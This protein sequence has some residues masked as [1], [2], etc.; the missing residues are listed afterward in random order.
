MNNTD[1]RLSIRVQSPLRVLLPPLLAVLAMVA[2]FFLNT[3]PA[4]EDIPRDD[5]LC[6]IDRDAITS[7]A[8]FLFDFA[9]P[10]DTAH[11]RLP[12]NLLHDMTL[13]LGRNTELQVFTL[14]DSAGAPRALLTR[15]CKPYDNADLQV[16]TARG[17]RSVDPDCGK[18]PA[19]LADNLRQSATAFCGALDALQ[20]ELNALAD[21]AW[22]DDRSV[23]NAY[24]VEALEDIGLELAERPGPHRLYVFS[25]MMQHASWYSHLD[26]KW[27][28]WNYDEFAKLLASRNW[29]FRQRDASAGMDVEIFYVPRSGT[30][31][32]PLAK[33]FH[34][35]FWRDY[36][37]D[38]EIAFHDQAAMR[39]YEAEPLMNVL[40]EAEMAARERAAIEQLLLE[41]EQEEQAM[42]RDQRELEAQ[43]ARQ[44]EARRQRQ[45][46]LQ[47]E[48]ERQR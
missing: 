31:S 27:M 34:Q 11:G 21:R 5:D 17:Q 6:P 7:S 10:L 33:E 23:A 29:L 12:G 15:L 3:D 24:L 30:T 22:P 48:L 16:N 38:S 25:D 9:K 40:S 44:T 1:A 32:Q 28:D 26:L 13:D 39:P 19:K 4:S 36:F 14:A 42:E 37:S 8:V 20:S 35:Q 18:L 2:L 47:L 45:A 43:L 41:L 46:E